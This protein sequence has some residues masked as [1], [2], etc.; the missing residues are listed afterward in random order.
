LSGEIEGG[1]FLTVKWDRKRYRSSEEA[2]AEIGVVGR[3]AE[4]AVHLTGTVEHAGTTV[5]LPIVLK[6][7]SDFQ[8]RVFFP[9][10]GDYTITV[11]ATLAGEPLDNYTRI[12]RVGSNVSEAADLAVDHPFLENLAARSGGAYSR[13]GDR[14]ALMRRLEALLLTSADPHDTPL[15]KK[16]A[17]FDLLPIYVIL[18]MAA[19]LWEWILRRRMNIV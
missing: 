4:G 19:M 11:E 7:G 14:E 12:I 3:Y 1:R 9:E 10:P 2:V 17:L 5:S 16:G 8:T 15:V 13:E 18:L 6:E